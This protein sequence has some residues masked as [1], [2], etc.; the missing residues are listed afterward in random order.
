MKSKLLLIG[1][2]L[3]SVLAV[4]QQKITVYQDCAKNEQSENE[5]DILNGRFSVGDNRQVYFSK[6]NLQYNRIL[7]IWRFAENQYDTL[8]LQQLTYV[9]PV[10]DGWQDVFAWGTGTNPTFSS[11]NDYDYPSFTDWG[12]NIIDNYPSNTWRTL[13]CDEWIYLFANRLNAAS[14][15]GGCTLNGIAGIIIFPDDCDMSQFSNFQSFAAVGERYNGQEYGTYGSHFNDNI[16]TLSEWHIF[17]QN[18]VIF[19][20]VTGRG[21]DNSLGGCYHSS[22]QYPY[23]SS[24][25]RFLLFNN[26]GLNPQGRYDK[27]ELRAVRL[28][29]DIE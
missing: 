23:L 24:W 4:A 29:Q 21:S 3:T 8:S 12:V 27:H 1:F 7:D 11:S 15:F 9:I 17:E 28:V 25:S 5:T 6:G 10:V 19:L 18:G 2:L 22:T 16:Y 26:A 14:L 20:P 13:S